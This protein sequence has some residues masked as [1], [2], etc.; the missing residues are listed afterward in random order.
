MNVNVIVHIAFGARLEPQLSVSA[1][2][3]GLIPLRVML[4]MFNVE[5]AEFDSF[6]T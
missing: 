2:S 5:L 3:P 1:K 4:D 6:K